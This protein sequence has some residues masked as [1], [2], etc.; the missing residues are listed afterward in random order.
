MKYLHIFL[1]VLVVFTIEYIRKYMERKTINKIETINKENYSNET[2]KKLKATESTTEYNKMVLSNSNGDLSSIGCPKGVIWLWSGSIDT[3]PDGWALCNG[4][5]GTPDLRG[6]F[7]LGVNP[8]TKPVPGLTVREVNAKGGSET[9]NHKYFDT[10][11]SENSGFKS[12]EINSPFD[13]TDARI[14]SGD[15]DYDNT[16]RGNWRYTGPG[17]EQ[18]LKGTDDQGKIMPP[19][20]TL[21]YIM[22]IV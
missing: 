9:H 21:A 4:D 12:G 19:Y 22:K 2:K 17:L 5:N 16:F 10:V 18:E 7:V 14:G 8:N 6:R 15:T 3:I 11:W 13:G 20:W 1:I